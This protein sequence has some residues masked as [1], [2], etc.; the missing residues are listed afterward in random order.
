MDAAHTSSGSKALD[1]FAMDGPSAGNPN[2]ITSSL[3]PLDNL[4]YIQ[5]AWYCAQG[6]IGYQ[7]CALISQHWLI[8]KIITMPAR[9]AMRHGYEIGTSDDD[10]I[11]PKIISY[12]KKRDKELRVKQNCVELVRFNRMFGIRIAMFVIDTEDDQFYQK[13]FN[14]DGVKPGSYRGISQIDPYWI[15]PELDFQ[16]GANPAAIHFYEPTWWRV[17]G[18][19]IH[20]SHLI[21]LRNGQVADILKPSYLYGG[22]SVPQKISERVY[23]AE[24]TANEA[25]QLALTKRTSVWKMDI[26][27]AIAQQT[28]FEQKMA[29]FSQTRDNFGVKAIGL[30]DEV[31]QLDTSLTDFSDTIDK[32]YAIACAAGD[33]PV[34][35]VM[36]T[37]ESGMGGGAAGGYDEGSYHELLES[38]QEND[39][40]PLVERHHLL[41]MKSEIVPKFKKDFEI[42]ILWNPT[43]SPTAKEQAELN[44]LKATTA[45]T[46]VEAGIIDGQDGRT[47]LVADKDSG[48]TTLEDDLPEGIEGE[49]ETNVRT[50]IKEGDA[51]GGA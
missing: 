7:I 47:V 19:R 46:L 35:K 25:P 29:W 24:R 20:R 3:S 31:Q 37:S 51:D 48:Y 4:P 18:Q 42:E 36:G 23:A 28:L 32:Q 30:D 12:I 2:A 15:T 21:V 45:K 39:C 34:N 50:T 17:N 9:D 40:Q 33:C 41:L 1:V 49:P 5:L 27:Q 44:G 11:D 22:V 6:F 10:E 16:A 26:A 38:I 14:I 13:P 8:D 43:D